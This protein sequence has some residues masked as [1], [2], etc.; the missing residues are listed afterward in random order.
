MKPDM[1]VMLLRKFG[2]ANQLGVNSGADHI[3]CRL[4]LGSIVVVFAFIT[5]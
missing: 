1:R 4:I 5:W 3:C 2:F